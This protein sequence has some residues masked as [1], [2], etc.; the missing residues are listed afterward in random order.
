MD[1]KSIKVLLEKEN[2]ELARTE[3][4]KLKSEEQ[5]KIISSLLA[6]SNLKL[7]RPLVIDDDINPN[8]AHKNIISYTISKYI[9]KT[10]RYNLYY[11]YR[12]NENNKNL[13]LLE[14]ILLS[15]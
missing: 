10:I 15:I 5:E 14:K 1:S 13:N 7:I 11:F 8:S 3:I 2:F 4:K 6:S 12:K 9:I